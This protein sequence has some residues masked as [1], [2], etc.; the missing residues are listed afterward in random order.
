MEVPDDLG[1]IVFI[2]IEEIVPEVD[3]LA[4]FLIILTAD[5]HARIMEIGTDQ[6]A[7]D[8]IRVELSDLL[9]DQLIAEIDDA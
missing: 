7:V 9:P 8:L 4:E 1:S 3:L 6:N 2:V 5:P